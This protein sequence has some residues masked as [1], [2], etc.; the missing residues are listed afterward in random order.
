MRH[1][2]RDA[3]DCVRSPSVATGFAAEAA[4]SWQAAATAVH[5]DV[6]LAVQGVAATREFWT[7]AAAEAARAEVLNLGRASDA[8]ARAW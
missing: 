7:G 2:G 5:A 8:L 1:G 4:D 6:E 3:S